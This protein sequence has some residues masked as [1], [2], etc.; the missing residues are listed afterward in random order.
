MSPSYYQKN[1]K[2]L[3]F[4]R[5]IV[6]RVVSGMPKALQEKNS[7]YPS[8]LWSF[9]VLCRFDTDTKLC[10]SSQKL[11]P[12]VDMANRFVGKAD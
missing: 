4:I 5:G 3:S 11:M 8:C 10:L 7:V 1:P 2:Y 6:P 12:N 9:T